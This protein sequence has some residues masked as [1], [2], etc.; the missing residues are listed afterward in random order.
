MIME[1]K[2]QIVIAG[3]KDGRS[4]K[5]KILNTTENIKYFIDGYALDYLRL[6]ISNVTSIKDWLN[7]ITFLEVHKRCLPP[8][9]H[10]KDHTIFPDLVFKFKGQVG[11]DIIESDKIA[12]INLRKISSVNIAMLIYSNQQCEVVL[13]FFNRMLEAFN[14]KYRRTGRTAL[15]IANGIAQFLERGSTQIVDHYHGNHTQSFYE[16]FIVKNFILTLATLLNVSGKD[17]QDI[18]TI[19]YQNLGGRCQG[20]VIIAYNK[21]QFQY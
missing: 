2:L 16:R 18:L 13:D 8:Y 5:D 9:L 17:I 21:G 19:K 10:Q 11:N 6:N 1:D 7:L 15:I 4:I 20:V 14:N 12:E 3:Y